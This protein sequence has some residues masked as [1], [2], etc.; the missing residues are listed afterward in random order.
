MVSLFQVQCYN[1]YTK[2]STRLIEP[3]V[4][5]APVILQDFLKL[6]CIVYTFFKHN[7]LTIIEQLVYMWTFLCLIACYF[8]T[9][10]T[11]YGIT[12]AILTETVHTSKS[13]ATLLRLNARRKSYSIILS[14]KIISMPSNF[15]NEIYTNKLKWPNLQ[16]IA[17]HDKHKKCNFPYLCPEIRK[18]NPYSICTSTLQLCQKWMNNNFLWKNI[19]H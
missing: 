2:L 14:W 3:N 16:N 13:Q 8:C 5:Y 18:V 11:L 10:S 1:C 15:S 4:S 7:N 12:T 6:S 19:W 9:A 17:Q